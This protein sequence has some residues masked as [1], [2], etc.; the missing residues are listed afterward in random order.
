MPD[1]VTNVTGDGQTNGGRSRFSAPALAP[2]PEKRYHRRGSWGGEVDAVSGVGAWRRLGLVLVSFLIAVPAL[3]SARSR[4]PQRG[5]WR[6]PVL[7][8]QFPVATDTPWPRQEVLDLAMRAYRCGHDAGVFDGDALTVIDYSLPSTE[9]RLWV[10]DVAQH[11]VLFHELVAHGENSG[12]NYASDFSNEPGSR[13]SSI[14]VFRTEDIYL[15][16]HGYALRLS[17]LEPG[18]NDAAMERKIVLH[19]APYVSARSVAMLG[20][21]GR[22]WGCPAVAPGVHRRLIDRIKG[23]SALF[24]YY[25]DA[26]WLKQSRFLQCD[27]SR[28]A[29]R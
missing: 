12:D 18:V 19:G 21:L 26:H 24:A 15:G 4:P 22:S 3:A 20:R 25:P 29:S 10:L 13:Q 6:R 27:V 11:R 2:V 23:G 8:S 9:K 17:G 16:G 28:M 7:R 5:V 1:G 14:G